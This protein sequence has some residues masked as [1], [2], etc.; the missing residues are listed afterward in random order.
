M[1]GGFIL[2]PLRVCYTLGE[3][4]A[5]FK[6]LFDIH[7]TTASVACKLVHK[8]LKVALDDTLSSNC[9]LCQNSIKAAL[10]RCC[11]IATAVDFHKSLTYCGD[12]VPIKV[13]IGR[14]SFRRIDHLCIVF[15]PILTLQDRVIHLGF[16]LTHWSD[17]SGIGYS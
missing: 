2:C 3:N 11:F 15:F 16:D 10:C 7:C 14:L 13:H 9:V 4:K 8:P 6:L 17:C 1:G 5:L 12:M